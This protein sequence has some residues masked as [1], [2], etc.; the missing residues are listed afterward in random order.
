M[1]ELDDLEIRVAPAGSTEPTHIIII[2]ALIL[3]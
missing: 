3:V 1:V 2:I